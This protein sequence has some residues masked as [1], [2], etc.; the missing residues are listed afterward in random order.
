MEL[1]YYMSRIWRAI[2]EFNLIEEN[3]CI[4]IGLSGGKD[5]LFLTHCLAAA[6]QY[7]PIKFKLAAYSMDGMFSEDFP[8]HKLTDFCTKLSMPF[9]TEKVNV[10]AVIEQQG[11]KDPCYSCAFFRRGAI[12]NFAARHGYNKVA[13]A[14]HLDDFVETFLMNILETG[15]IGTFM[16]R[17]FLDRTGVTVIRPLCYIRE[18]ELLDTHQL[19][20]QTALKN[21]CPYDGK[22]KRQY[23]KEMIAKLESEDPAK[24]SHLVAA[25]RHKK[26]PQLWPQ[27][28][29]KLE[30]REEF[31]EFWNKTRS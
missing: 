19:T 15:Q 13:Y 17:T 25:M 29:S 30:L 3:D 7:S 10:K 6:R 20:G 2:I 28:K 24:F 23:Y 8:S 21:P 12:N 22:T 16:P 4:L 5:S 18:R 31:R 11:G 9:F 1:K 26:Q 14:H 27:E